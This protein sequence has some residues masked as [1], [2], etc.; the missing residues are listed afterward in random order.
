VA[1]ALLP[2]NVVH[3]LSLK[4]VSDATKAVPCKR[5]GLFVL[6]LIDKILKSMII[7]IFTENGITSRTV[8]ILSKYN[9]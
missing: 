4:D 7:A 5:G 6:W 8:V 9:V 2:G 3:P 1:A